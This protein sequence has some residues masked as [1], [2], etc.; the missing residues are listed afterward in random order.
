MAQQALFLKVIGVL[1]VPTVKEVNVRSDAGTNQIL[2][3]KIPVGTSN[4]QVLEVK[5]DLE[6][7]HFNGKTYQWLRVAF[8]QGLGWV[9][10]D[11]V[12]IW[13]DGTKYGYPLLAQP[14]HAFSLTVQVVQPSPAPQQ[15]AAP[16]QPLITPP[17]TTT[18]PVTSTQPAFVLKAIGL[19]NNPGV[20]EVNIRSDAGTNQALIFKV[21]VGTSN[22]QILE[23]KADVES[24]NFNGKVYQWFRAAFTQGQGWV[25][26]DLVEIS[27]DGTKFGYPVL[28]Q[29]TVGFNLSRS[30]TPT[31]PVPSTAPVST[32][33]SSPTTT[34]PA[35][36]VAPVAPSVPSASS[37]AMATC[38]GKSGVN[39]RSGAGSMY[40]QIMRINYKEKVNVLDTKAGEDNP[41]FHWVKVNYQGREGWV[42]EDYVRMSG[43][44]KAFNLQAP[45][46]YPS[47]AQSSWW[48]RGYDPTSVLY[49]TGPHHGWDHGGDRGAPLLAGP[50]GGVVFD[51]VFCA[52]CG[53]EGVSTLERGFKVGDSSIFNDP[54]WNF[55][56]GHYV[57]V[58]Y[59]SSKLPESTKQ[60]LANNNKAGWHIFVMYA[61]LQ[62]MLVQKGAQVAPNQQIALMGNSGNSEASHLHL[63]IRAAQ[64]MAIPS[65]AQIKGGLMSPG[66]LFGF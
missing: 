17:A 25:R 59:E 48:V 4:L 7:R 8:P 50:Q 54:S 19:P 5:A 23:A 27:G 61:H 2:L 13:G 64:T 10:D 38:M 65:W 37:P 1:N 55:G 63:E 46:K 18:A 29:G 33:P 35:Q 40:Q 58:G 32:T 52:R 14:A 9:R 44:F 51:A 43:N 53:N 16:Q 6:K 15:P 39:M 47:P 49:N 56:Y 3:F 66:V 12:E 24:R 57:I 22:V 11:M 30:A 42:R 26:D 34:A 45:D 20:T 21:P 60:Y 31:Q 62:Q 28:A 36:P 41:A